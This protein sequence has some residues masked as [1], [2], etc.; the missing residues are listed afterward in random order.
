MSTLS[1]QRSP[2]ERTCASHTPPS[3]GT[4]TRFAVAPITSAVPAGRMHQERTATAGN[5]AIALG[6]G[7]IPG[8]PGYDK[9]RP[10]HAKWP[11]TVSMKTGPC[12]SRCGLP[13]KGSTSAVQVAQQ[14]RDDP[15]VLGVVGHPE[16]GNTPGSHS[17]IRRRATRWHAT[18]SLP[19][20][21]PHHRRACPASVRGSFASPRATTKPRAYVAR[22]VLDSLG[23]TR[24]AIMY[25][26]DSYGRDWSATIRRHL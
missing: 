10:R 21:P 24:A 4:A 14:L 15:T 6:V 25:R 19:S 23:A 3:T 1:F 2:D 13:T 7:A 9:H 11:L 17:R 8:R 5:G 22:W 16:S 12:D 20:R 18:P 26:N